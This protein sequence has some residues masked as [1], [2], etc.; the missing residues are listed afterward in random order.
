M[1]FT[2][3]SCKAYGRL[4]VI[5]PEMRIVS[6]LPLALA[7]LFEKGCL[8]NIVLKV[9]ICDQNLLP[10]VGGALFFRNI[11]FSLKKK[12]KKKLK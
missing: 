3:Q 5:S 12:R 8:K 6:L 9:V 7:A 10:P 11:K 2:Y 1:T 4:S